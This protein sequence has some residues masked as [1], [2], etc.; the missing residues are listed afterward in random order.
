MHGDYTCRLVPAAYHS[1]F[2]A[3]T[4]VVNSDRSRTFLLSL[5]WTPPLPPV[6]RTLTLRR[7]MS[8]AAER[9]WSIIIL[10]SNCLMSCVP[11]TS[12]PPYFWS[13]AISWA[14]HI[15]N[16]T[17]VHSLGYKSPYDLLALVATSKT[18]GIAGVPLQKFG[19]AVYMH[20]EPQNRDAARSTCQK[21]CWRSVPHWES[22]RLIC[23]TTFGDR[24]LN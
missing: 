20:L 11:G 15:A 6:H 24:I 13:Y 23:R 21:C 14:A 12:C 2:T 1:L 10:G 5:W 4:A 16:S 3:T 22:A 7:R 17:P 8:G 19:A 18:I 9:S